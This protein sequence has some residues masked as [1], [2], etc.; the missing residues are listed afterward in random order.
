MANRLPW[1]RDGSLREEQGHV[2]QGD[3][4]RV[5]AVLTRFL[6]AL[7]DFLGV[8]PVPKQMRLCEAPPLL[9]VRLLLG[10]LLTF[11]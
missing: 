1:R 10:S 8:S 4:P 9:A 2:R 5:L 11:E 7:L 3:A 6:W